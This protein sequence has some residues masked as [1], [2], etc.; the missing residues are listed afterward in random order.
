VSKA[1]QPGGVS[2]GFNLT[3][4]G[5][6]ESFRQQAA[7]R[8]ESESTKLHKEEVKEQKKTNDLLAGIKALINPLAP[9]NL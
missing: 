4:A 8:R 7:M 3:R 2:P 5:S 6:V 1:L 9:A